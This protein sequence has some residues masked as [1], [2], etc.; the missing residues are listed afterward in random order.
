MKIIDFIEAWWISAQP[1]FASAGVTGQFERS[2]VD[3][4]RAYPQIQ[5][6]MAGLK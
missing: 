2:P 6:R 4:L 3:R 1:I 5:L